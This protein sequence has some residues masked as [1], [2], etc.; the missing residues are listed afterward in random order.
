MVHILKWKFWDV[1]VFPIMRLREAP[2]SINVLAT[3]CHS[4]GVFTMKGKF[5]MDS[6]VSGWSSRPNEILTSDYFIILP[7]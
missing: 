3:L 6:S 2:L 4:I 5:L 7:R 1:T